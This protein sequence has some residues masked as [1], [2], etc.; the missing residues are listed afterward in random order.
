MRRS[1]AGQGRAR[2]GSSPARRRVIGF[3]MT[4]TAATAPDPARVID[5]AYAW[6]RLAIS[7]LLS[8]IGGVGMWSVVVMLPS[9]EAEFGV[10]RAEATLP[11]TFTMLGVMVGGVLM[12]RVA[13]RFGVMAASLAGTL[14]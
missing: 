2:V 6:R 13:D 4:T 8:T 7:V 10:A 1:N 12:G 3:L 11:Y 5:S 14:S 9:I